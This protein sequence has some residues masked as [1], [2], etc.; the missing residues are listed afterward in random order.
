MTSVGD[1]M[2]LNPESLVRG[3]VAGREIKQLRGRC[4]LAQGDGPT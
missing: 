4:V 2:S 3:L 1:R